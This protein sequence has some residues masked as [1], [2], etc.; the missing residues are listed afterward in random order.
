VNYDPKLMH[1]RAEAL[2]I[3][4]LIVGAPAA[5]NAQSPS[6]APSTEAPA[7]PAPASG[8]APSSEED[9]PAGD[10]AVP[11]PPA[12]G[13]ANRPLTEPSELPPGSIKRMIL[14]FQKELRDSGRPESTVEKPLSEALRAAERARGARAAGDGLHGGMLERLARQ[15]IDAG[16]AVLEAVAIEE[17]AAEAAAEAQQLT[18]KLERAEALLVEQQA[19]LGRLKAEI[20]EAGAAVD[21]DKAA[22]AESEAERLDKAGKRGRKK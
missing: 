8:A 20:E 17:R 21:D 22:A 3:G 13:G 2:L 19:R 18:T 4:T 14:D 12:S 9:G 16:K 5:A 1:G 11:V 6:P 15:W 7:S 10:Q